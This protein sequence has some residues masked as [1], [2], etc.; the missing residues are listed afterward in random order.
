M[1]GFIRYG[2]SF[3]CFYIDFVSDKFKKHNIKYIMLVIYI[4]KFYY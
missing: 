2:K 4:K 1:K 3:L